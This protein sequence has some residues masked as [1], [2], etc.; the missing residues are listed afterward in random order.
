VGQN[1]TRV[2]GADAPP[3]LLRRLV[4]EAFSFYGRYWAQAAILGGRRNKDAFGTWDMTGM[5]FLDEARAQGRGVILAMPHVGSWEAAAAY[6][7][8][9]GLY[10]TSVAEVLDPPELF[11][12]FVERRARVGLTVLPIGAANAPVLL[13]VLRG[14]GTLGLLCD[15]DVV[16]DGV[17]VEFFGAKTRLPGGPAVLALRSGAAL[18]PAA[19]YSGS[20]NHHSG[21]IEKPLDTS[22]HGTLREDIAAITTALAHEFEGFIRKAPAQWHAFQP[23]WP[24]AFDTMD[25]PTTSEGP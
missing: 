5:E 12:F 2:I 20:A 3:E 21:I 10:I 18:L 15:R 16:G 8:H 1:L 25:A 23:I 7:S 24:D 19:V 13:K 4:H 22:R 14:G 9:G 17:V 6:L 11:D